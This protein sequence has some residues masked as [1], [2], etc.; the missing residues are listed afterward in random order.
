M[1]CES[2][3][4]PNRAPPAVLPGG[5]KGGI[6]EGKGRTGGIGLVLRSRHMN[7]WDSDCGMQVTLENKAEQLDARQGTNIFDKRR[8]EEFR[9]MINYRMPV[10]R[11]RLGKSPMN[12]ETVP[13]P[14]L[15]HCWDITKQG[16]FPEL[17]CNSGTLKLSVKISHLFFGKLQRGG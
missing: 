13:T 2:E 14:N 10:I 5:R 4:R 15:V 16:D 11:P 12:T 6:C 9:C 1:P 17:G 3:K 7:S 8:W